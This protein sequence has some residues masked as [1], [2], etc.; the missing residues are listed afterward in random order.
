MRCDLHVIILTVAV[1]EGWDLEEGM[2]VDDL[3]RSLNASHN[4]SLAVCVK[5]IGSLTPRE[6]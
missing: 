2:R 4:S 5:V 6:W 1:M 3:G